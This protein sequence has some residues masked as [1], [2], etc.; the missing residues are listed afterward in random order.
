MVGFQW[1]V[2][3]VL[4]VAITIAV[5]WSIGRPDDPRGHAVIHNT[6]LIAVFTGLTSA[7]VFLV[8]YITPL[9]A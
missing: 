9:L 4:L 7:V 1:I 6:T 3:S 5:S 2:L 8:V